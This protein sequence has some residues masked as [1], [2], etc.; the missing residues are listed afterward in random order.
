MRSLKIVQFIDQ[1]Q[2][3]KKQVLCNQAHD[4]K[5]CLA[6]NTRITAF[7]LFT[8][9]LFVP[10]PVELLF[11]SP[12]KK[13]RVKF[14]FLSCLHSVNMQILGAKNTY[15]CPQST[16]RGFTHFKRVFLD[17]FPEQ[18]LRKNHLANIGTILPQPGQIDK[19]I[20]N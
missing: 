19:Y 5:C 7:I 20:D 14:T 3:I 6:Q 11:A 12:N 8:V 17:V 18:Y 16:H 9:N 15:P 2:K 10:K 4:S 1:F 13:S